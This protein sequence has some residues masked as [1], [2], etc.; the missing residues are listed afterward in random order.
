MTWMVQ[1]TLLLFCILSAPAPAGAQDFRGR[2]N[3]TVTDNTGAVLPGVTVTA[4]SP[5]LIQPQVQVTGADGAYRF[6]ALP[7]G[8]YDVDLRARR[9]PDASSAKACASSSTDADRRPAA[10][11]RHA[12]GDRH[13]DRRLAHRRHVHDA[14]RHQLHQGAADGHPQRA[15]HLG[16]HGAGARHPDDAATT[17]A[18]RAPARRPASSP[19]AS[20]TRTRRS[21]KA[22]TPPRA[23]A[24]TP[25]TS[26]SAASRSSRSAAPAP[27]PTASAAAPT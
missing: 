27:A 8:V 7:P 1:L 25:A 24:P 10:A 11:G 6:I 23:P 18:A 21:S 14:G 20:A 3:G 17:W 26:T 4:T 5:A 9:L 15:R 16:R 19:T 22:S 13:R 12:A 2:I